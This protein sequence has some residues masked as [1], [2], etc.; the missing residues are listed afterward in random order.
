VGLAP[1]G[2]WTTRL[3]RSC[4]SWLRVMSPDSMTLRS[5]PPLGRVCPKKP[6]M[7]SILPPC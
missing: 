4:C 3:S 5:T 6:C 2:R 1:G 7:A